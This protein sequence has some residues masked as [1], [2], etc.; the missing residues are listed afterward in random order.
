[1]L[2]L[3]RRQGRYGEHLTRLLV[4]AAGYSSSKPED[5]GDGVDLVVSHTQHDGQTRRPPNLELQVKT[6][7]GPRLV[8]GL[9]G[10]S[11]SYDLE[12]AH[13]NALR[14]P[15]PTARLLVVV[16]VPGDQPDKW[17]GQGERFLAF[18]ESA[19]Y[20]DLTG[21]PATAN[22]TKIAV[23]LPLAQ[24]FTPAIVDREMRRARAAQRARFGLTVDAAL[25]V[26]G[27]QA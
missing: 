9:A 10:S 6:V 17:Y 20:V 15:G 27:G 19:H 11:L 3:D 23:H 22:R 12:L 18:Q 13:Y 25:Q 5:D 7:R 14:L 16:V 21:E 1:M 4:T 26:P 8:N 24:R 2:D